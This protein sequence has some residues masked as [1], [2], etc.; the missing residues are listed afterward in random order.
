[1][2]KRNYL[3]LLL[4]PLLLIVAGCGEDTKGINLNLTFDDVLSDEDF[5][6]IKYDYT[7]GKDF[8]GLEKDMKVFFYFQRMKD[9]K[10]L[11]QDDHL[12][13]KKTTEWKAGD[14][15]SYE[16]TFFLHK[17][18]DETEVELLD[19][20]GFEEVKVTVGLYDPNNFKD[21]IVLFKKIVN[22]EP[23][24]A[25][26][27]ELDYAEGW[28]NEEYNPEAEGFARTWRWT[29][30]KALCLV[31]NIN[32]KSR[33]IIKGQVHHSYT[34]EQTI[35]IKINDKVLDTFTPK[36]GDFD[37]EYI[38]EPSDLGDDVQFRL[39]FEASQSFTPSKLD[40]K[41]MDNRE[42]AFMINFLYFREYK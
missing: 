38:L 2:R 29:Q 21:R 11:L 39:T 42:L 30:K 8:K 37:K 12:L 35:T 15:I 10:M 32:K 19:F 13:D 40:P 26:S 22:I 27:P 23:V 25:V 17:F 3:I 36:E 18:I 28:N 33:L 31:E 34:P 9:K 7:L 16:R 14:K 4:I 20:E 41:N 6:K 5:I 24:S 1:M